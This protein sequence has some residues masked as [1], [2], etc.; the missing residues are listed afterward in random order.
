MYS[1]R[2]RFERHEGLGRRAGVTWAGLCLATGLVLGMLCGCGSS[3]RDTM[4]N[5]YYLN[6]QE[7]VR[8][9]GRVT[10]VE[11]D[12]MS[13][14]PAISVDMSRALFLELQKKQVFSVATIARDD[15]AWH[16]LQENLDT[17]QAMQALLQMRERLRCNGL[18]VG[19]ITE[20]R[21][22]PRLAIGLRLKLLDLSNG[23]I[24]WGVEQVWDSTD[25]NLQKRMQA[26]FRKQRRS[27]SNP[28]PEQL[29]GVSSLEF[30]KFAAYEV[31]QTLDG[32]K[33][34]K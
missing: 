11:L 4:A 25:R 33:K 13:N 9:L 32:K 21:S 26:Y 23:Q 12:N 17:L 3:D 8:E 14:Y 30:A 29:V 28:L 10:L 2:G 20:Y 31:A 34:K 22:Y 24:L 6:S 15:P 7:N 1:D 16:P 5:A 27:G 19:T 18:L